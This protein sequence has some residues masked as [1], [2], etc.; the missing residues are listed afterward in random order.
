MS[1][2][3]PALVRGLVFDMD[4]LLLDSEKLVKR[5]WNYAGSL[6][7]YEDFGDHIYNTVGFNLKRRTRYFRE[8]VSEDFP[9]EWFADV[10]RKKYH[11]IADEEGV[12]VKAGARELL[13]YAKEKD[14]RIGLATS[15]RKIH[16]E[17]SLKS[18]GL[19]CY[20]DGMVFG[21]VVKEGKP[22]PEI[23]LRA[24]RQIGVEPSEAVALE[25]APSGVIS[26]HA[27]GMRVIVVPDLVEP[28][29][30][31]IGLVWHRA[32]SLAEVPAMLEEERGVMV[33]KPVL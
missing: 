31:I 33:Q 7:G 30:E 26:A 12:E 21:D 6:L 19:F 16:A 15:S 8:N 4:G 22:A 20:F 14:Y 18:A 29:E 25:D 2:C 28:P 5:T 3:G 9:M 17:Q 24:C 13:E 27:A 32:E 11:E 1:E 23:Y 10:T